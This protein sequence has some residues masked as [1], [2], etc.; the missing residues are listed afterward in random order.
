MFGKSHKRWIQPWYHGYEYECF[1]FQV[2]VP[3][4]ICLRCWCECVQARTD[5]IVKCITTNSCIIK[6]GADYRRKRKNGIQAK[7]LHI[8]LKREIKRE[9]ERARG[10]WIERRAKSYFKILFLIR[11]NFFCSYLLR[12]HICMYSLWSQC[13][14]CHL[15]IMSWIFPAV[16]PYRWIGFLFCK[17]SNTY[18]FFLSLTKNEIFF[19]KFHTM[20]KS[21]HFFI[22][23]N[24]II[25]F[26]F[27]RSLKLSQTGYLNSFSL[28]LNMRKVI[29]FKND[30]N[31]DI[32]I[33]WF[34]LPHLNY[35]PRFLEKEN[36]AFLSHF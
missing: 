29:K 24:F 26:L 17:Y 13:R 12:F 5:C 7:Y 30:S 9:R 35:L 34:F 11:N 14:F 25:E 27:R 1:G 23:W 8:K 16:M 28:T 2:K 6:Y 22:F 3:V 21:Y 31:W 18:C 20:N 19:I 10:S 15:E 33:G 32:F 36:C 4:Q